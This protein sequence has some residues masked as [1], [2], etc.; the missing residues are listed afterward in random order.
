MRTARIARI[1]SAADVM[2]G[3][4]LM[5]Q[6]LYAPGGDI[7]VR[8]GVTMLLPGAGHPGGM[9]VLL[10]EDEVELAEAVA[11]VLRREGIAVDVAF[12]GREAL[13]RA[14]VNA[15]D[16]VVLDRDLPQVH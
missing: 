11:R 12:D 9:R 4:S 15:Y 8:G 6:Q 14:S 5:V 13:D 7:A 2:A 10:V 3:L 1:A 16:V